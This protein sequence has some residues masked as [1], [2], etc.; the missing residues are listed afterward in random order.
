MIHEYDTY[1]V[2][3]QVEEVMRYG[4]LIFKY[5]FYCMGIGLVLAHIFKGDILPK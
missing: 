2:P 4:T 5:V 3:V 1:D